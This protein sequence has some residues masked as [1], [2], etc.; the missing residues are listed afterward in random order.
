MHCTNK[1]LNSLLQ[2]WTYLEARLV[3]S[4]KHTPISRVQVNDCFLVTRKDIHIHRFSKMG[5]RRESIRSLREL[6][7]RVDYQHF[8]DAR[9]KM[10]LSR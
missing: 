9:R 1:M 10:E 6:R 5:C 3:V 2:R 7:F 8:T 4:I